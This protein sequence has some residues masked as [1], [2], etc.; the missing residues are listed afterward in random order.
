MDL[1]AYTLIAVV[2]TFVGVLLGRRSAT[3][4][5]VADRL[6]AEIDEIRARTEVMKRNNGL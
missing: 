2:F 1:I 3:A 6:Q 5:K 4:N